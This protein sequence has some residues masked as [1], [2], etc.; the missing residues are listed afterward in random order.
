MAQVLATTVPRDARPPDLRASTLLVKV[1]AATG[2]PAA[3]QVKGAAGCSVN[4]RESPWVTLLA[5]TWHFLRMV[6]VR[7]RIGSFP[8]VAPAVCS[9]FGEA[10]RV[11]PPGPAWLCTRLTA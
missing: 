4:D 8:G 10:W 5:G 3:A 2:G 9:R 7:L 11:L 6:R 1:V